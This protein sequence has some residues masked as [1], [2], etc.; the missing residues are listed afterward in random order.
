MPLSFTSTCCHLILMMMMVMKMIFFGTTVKIK[1][2][3][4]RFAV[5]RSHAVRRKHP[6]GLL[7]TRAQLV[8]PS[9]RTP[10]RQRNR[11]R[12]YDCGNQ[13]AAE[14]CLIPHYHQDRL[15]II[16][17]QNHHYRCCCCCCRRSCVTYVSN[18]LTHKVLN[19]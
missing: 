6:V 7:C 13:A 4:P 16:C 8:S 5:S 10:P 14:P 3:P 12:I 18:R 2:R 19:W 1:P 17:D 11:T 9:Q 15:M